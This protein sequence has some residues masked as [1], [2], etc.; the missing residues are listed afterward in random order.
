M[1]ATRSTKELQQRA[2]WLASQTFVVLA[3]SVPKDN[4]KKPQ[5]AEQFFAAIHGIYRNNPIEQE[6][7]SFE[8]VARKDAITFYVFTPIHLRDFVEGQLYAQ[9]PNLQI[10]QVG[11]YTSQV[12]L[13][14]QHV[15]TTRVKLNKPD[16][17]PIKTF[18]SSEVDP[19]AGITAVLS[20]LEEKEQVW[21]QISTRPVGDD[22]QGVGVKYV[23]EMR[24]TGK[25]PGKAKNN[26]IAAKLGRGVMRV[27]KEMTQPGSGLDEVKKPDEVKLSSPQ[28]AALKGIESKITKLGFEIIFRLVAVSSTEVAAKARVQAV[29]AALKQFNTTNLNGF[30]GAEIKMDDYDAWEQYLAR[31]FE[32]K[33]NIL[34]IE[35]LASIYHF[36]S[37]EVETSAISWAGSKKGEAPFNLPLVAKNDPVNLTV[38][39]K[40]DFRDSFQEFGIKMDDRMRHI[41]VIGKS[42]TGKST[43]LENMAIG[44]VMQGRGVIVVDPHGEFADKVIDAIPEHRIKDVIVFDPSDR[45]FPIAFNI[46]DI[47]HPDQKNNIASGFV[48]ALKKIFGNSWGP[49][50]EYILR[51][52]TLALLDTEFP[53]MLGIPRILTDTA[54][55][56]EVIAQIKDPVVLDFWKNEWAA[57][58]Q[59]QQVEEMGSILNKVGQFLSSNLIRNIVGQPKSGFDMRQAMDEQKILI[60]NLSK[61]KIGE[62]NSA[63]LGTMMITKVQL[64]AMSRADVDP[65]RRPASFLYVDEFQNFATDSFA[66][67]LSEARKYNLGL[68]IAHQYIAQMAPEVKDA[69]F[70]NVGSMISFR[71]GSEDAR[72]LTPEFTPVFNEND[73]VN[74]Q[75]GHVYIKLLIDGLAVPAFS[76]QTAP[77]I[78]IANSYRDQVIEFS[79]ATYACSRSEAEEIIDETAGYKKRRQVEE[80]ARQAKEALQQGTERIGIRPGGGAAPAAAPTAP[81]AWTPPVPAST[82]VS[83][84]PALAPKVTV[85][86]P[87]TI[88]A[89]PVITTAPVAV[90]EP[91]APAAPAPVTVPPPIT[92]QPVVESPAPVVS[93][94]DPVEEGAS[95]LVPHEEITL[96][97]VHREIAVT[98]PAS[99]PAEYEQNTNIVVDEMPAV[100]QILP[101]FEN[102]GGENAPVKERVEKPL[103]V[104]DGWVYKEVAQRGGLRWYLGEQEEV[105]KARLEEK[106]RLKEAQMLAENGAEKD[107]ADSP[108]PVSPSEQSANKISSEIEVNS[109]QIQADGGGSVSDNSPTEIP[110]QEGGSIEF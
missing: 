62:D 101:E 93:T 89:V 3:I 41:Y 98:H 70:G 44:D 51:N 30:V 5:S 18:T 17:Y 90:V 67:I 80:A 76:A 66:T 23:Q 36:P 15:A 45:D 94:S 65:S 109:T 79:R 56:N 12:E 21:L 92:Q 95:S 39:G 48:G 1:A 14:G 19:L 10:R 49:R 63:L 47:T 97:E 110:L 86:T 28:E 75:R 13:E 38:L 29:L 64:A 7:I 27:I 40:T 91:P 25:E 83:S 77:P 58:E 88:P 8:I 61:G 78:K 50:L 52:A 35:E 99:V 6:H 59:K 43:L 106:R 33:G 85:S 84:T 24:K 104:M 73:L 81:R 87:A 82:P 26:A 69:V 42:G 71:V 32:E 68:T 55:R 34:N 4:D 96:T 100:P 37:Q 74:L 20:G 57:K 107:S 11:D 60:V 72:A 9:Y 103:K 102:G 105:L 16:V 54:F 108:A 22:W 46:L 31:E 53:T 2:E